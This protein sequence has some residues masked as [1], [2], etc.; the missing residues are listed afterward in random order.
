MRRHGATTGPLADSTA[1]AAAR[2]SNIDELQTVMMAMNSRLEALATFCERSIAVQLADSVAAVPRALRPSG[3]GKHEGQ[4]DWSLHR[5]GREPGLP[6]VPDLPTC[7]A[8][9]SRVCLC[10]GSVCDASDFAQR[11]GFGALTEVQTCVPQIEKCWPVA[12]VEEVV[13][14]EEQSLA[15]SDDDINPRRTPRS[16]RP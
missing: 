2:T 4:A 5:V 14:V 13:E 6:G 1:A 7:A 15:Q 9:S 11:M 8:N 3:A 12:T 16:S 10:M